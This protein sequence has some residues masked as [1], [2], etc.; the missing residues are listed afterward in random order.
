MHS[1]VHYLAAN[2]RSTYDTLSQSHAQIAS[3]EFPQM[4]SQIYLRIFRRCKITDLPNKR[5]ASLF[6]PAN[7]GDRPQIDGVARLA[8]FR[9]ESRGRAILP[10]APHP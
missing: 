5:E 6:I 2:L 3:G 10:A 9:V 4:A 8:Q 7:I 1:S